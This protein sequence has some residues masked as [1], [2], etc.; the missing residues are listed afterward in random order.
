MRPHSVSGETGIPAHQ[1]QLDDNGSLSL[2]HA[3]LQDARVSKQC[4]MC[5]VMHAL[6]WASAR[7]PTQRS[8]FLQRPWTVPIALVTSHSCDVQL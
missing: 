8:G 3:A 4:V 5:P 1:A 7:A 6:V 2:Q